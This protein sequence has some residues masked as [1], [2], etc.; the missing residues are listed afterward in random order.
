MV[1]FPL[2]SFDISEYV[3]NHDLPEEYFTK[4]NQNNSKKPQLLY[5]LI[6][7][8]NHFGGTGGGHYTAYCEYFFTYFRDP[9][10]KKWYDFDD[11]CV[12]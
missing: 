8:T 5:D 2:Q 7:I 10:S 12:D 3:I 6:G 9:R 4:E 1:D 11:S